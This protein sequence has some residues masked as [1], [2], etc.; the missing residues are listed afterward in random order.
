MFSVLKFSVK[1]ELMVET[2]LTR[3]GKHIK[4]FNTGE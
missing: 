3:F 4:K 2:T 1:S